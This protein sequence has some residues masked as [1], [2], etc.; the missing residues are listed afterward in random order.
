MYC[1]VNLLDGFSNIFLVDATSISSPKYMKVGVIRNAGRL[2]H[3]MRH[4]H[5]RHFSL[6][7]ENQTL[8]LGGGDWIKR[9]S[10]LVKQQHFR[11]GCECAGDAQTLLL[12]AGEL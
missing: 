8:D 5:H 11:V 3:V 1:S 9:G 10:R 6:Q 2:L 7:F 12:A 4:D